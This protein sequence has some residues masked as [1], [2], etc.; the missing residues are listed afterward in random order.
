[1]AHSL[2][3]INHINIECKEEKIM[4]ALI[5]KLAISV[6]PMFTLIITAMLLDIHCRKQKISAHGKRGLL[7]GMHHT[8][9]TGA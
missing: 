7:K 4:K 5:I 1:L 2:K 8:F 3:S 9:T 6:I